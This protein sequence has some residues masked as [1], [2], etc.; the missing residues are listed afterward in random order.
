MILSSVDLPQPEGPMIETNSPLLMLILISFSAVVSI[1]SV[2]KALVTFCNDSM[3][4]PR[5]GPVFLCFLNLALCLAVTQSCFRKPHKYIPVAPIGI[6]ADEVF[7]NRTGSLPP[8]FSVFD[9]KKHH[10]IWRKEGGALGTI[11]Y[12]SV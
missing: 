5:F 10:T 9:Q 6:H 11:A 4:V 8:T 12:S 1:S 2:R 7:R 3:V